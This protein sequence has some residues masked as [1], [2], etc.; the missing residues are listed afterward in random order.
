M[1]HAGPDDGVEAGRRAAQILL[2]IGAVLFRPQQ[3]FFFSSG[4]ASPV[5]VDCKRS[6]SYPLARDALVELSIRRIMD[7]LGYDAIDAVAGAEGGGVPFASVIAH[8][9]HL[10]LVVSR[11]HAAGIG[12]EA[13]TFG[14]LSAGRRLLLI[15]DV[16]TDGRTKS[17]MCQLLRS[18]G[19]RVEHVFVLFKYGIFD[20]VVSEPELGVTLFSLATWKEL[21]AVARERR[22][23]D[24]AV[25]AEMQAYVE[26]P[27]GWSARHGGISALRSG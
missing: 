16:T 5:Y 8:R 20:S 24:D 6:I 14:H 10:P 12:P 7:V 11:K 18:A 13:G 1:P 9:L 3:P 26:D 27:P 4:W 2:D 22:S 17:S 15:D 21:L 23:F 25:L 19:Y